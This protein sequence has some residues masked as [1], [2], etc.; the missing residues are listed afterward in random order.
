M[1]IIDQDPPFPPSAM[2]DIFY[3]TICLVSTDS[4]QAF[5]YTGVKMKESKLA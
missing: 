5:E 1:D 3:P 2:G 4:P